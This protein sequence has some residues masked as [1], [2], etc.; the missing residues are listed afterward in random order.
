[1]KLKVVLCS[2][3]I[4]L[5]IA[6]ISIATSYN[7]LC[8][9]SKECAVSGNSTLDS[10]VDQRSCVPLDLMRTLKAITELNV[11]NENEFSLIFFIFL[12]I[13]LILILTFQLYFDKVKEQI[14]Q[15]FMMTM[16]MVVYVSSVLFVYSMDQQSIKGH[17]NGIPRLMNTVEINAIVFFI[18]VSCCTFGFDL[19][20]WLSIPIPL[21]FKLTTRNLSLA[22][23]IANLKNQNS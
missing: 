12:A 2:F 10:Y 21:K 16:E 6:V 14:F 18:L 17:G 11:H 13:T 9:P 15:S 7:Q 3:R 8:G 20:L 1:M 22:N 23:S 5:S 19:L 4:L